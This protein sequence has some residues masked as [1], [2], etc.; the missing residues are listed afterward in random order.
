MPIDS[1]MTSD[2]VLNL[3]LPNTHW[4]ELE[5]YILENSSRWVDTDI[6]WDISGLDLSEVHG[7]DVRSFVFKLRNIS[8]FRT[9][10]KTA[11]VAATDI[12]YGM[13]HMLVMLAENQFAFYLNVFRTHD[14][15]VEWLHQSETD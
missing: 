5:Q 15:A 1:Q 6:I 7:A 14:E 9:G 3:V 4:F 8:Q 2:Y 13:M 12:A 11:V 10:L